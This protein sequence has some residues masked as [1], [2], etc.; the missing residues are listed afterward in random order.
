MLACIQYKSVE[1]QKPKG[2]PDFV[3][4]NTIQGCFSNVIFPGFESF[5][6]LLLALFDY[7][8]LQ[9]ARGSTLVPAAGDLIVYTTLVD[10]QG[11]TFSSW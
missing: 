4:Y 7:F 2:I 6:Y 10:L 3:S 8:Q 1:T 9:R 5:L 11:C